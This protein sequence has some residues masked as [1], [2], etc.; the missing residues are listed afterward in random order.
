MSKS[1]NEVNLIGNLGQD[2]EIRATAAG[3]AVMNFSLATSESWKDRKTAE[4]KE[5]TEWHRVVLFGRLAEA[6]EP[7][8]KKGAKVFVKGQLRTRKWQAQNGQDRYTTEIVV[9]TGGNLILL[10]S[11]QAAGADPRPLNHAGSDFQR[12]PA[13]EVPP[14]D[15]D[16]DIPF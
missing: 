5:R 7:H 10:D 11:R 2:P 12:P 4:A 14:M 9:G 1:L 15:L 8:L 3:D 16:D 6:I 13:R